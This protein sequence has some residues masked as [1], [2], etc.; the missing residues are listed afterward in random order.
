MSDK[1]KNISDFQELKTTGQK[2]TRSTGNYQFFYKLPP[3]TLARLEVYNARN[4]NTENGF[5]KS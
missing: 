2:S 3:F 5:Q 1:N 4:S